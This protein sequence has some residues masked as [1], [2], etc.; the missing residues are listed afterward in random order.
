M[1]V[2]IPRNGS[3]VFYRLEDMHVANS[4]NMISNGKHEFVTATLT[5]V[6][7]QHFFS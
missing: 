1:E 6:S 2:A 4:K 3:D 7:S 5:S